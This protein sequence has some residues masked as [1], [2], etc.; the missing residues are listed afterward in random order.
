ML[1]NL[2]LRAQS[3]IL[4]LYELTGYDNP[5]NL[6]CSFVNLESDKSLN[7]ECVQGTSERLLRV[8]GQKS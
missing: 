2:L 8:G 6:R 7:S 1:N 5:L 4:S 3:L